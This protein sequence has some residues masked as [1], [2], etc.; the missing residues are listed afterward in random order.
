M[1]DSQQ[2]LELSIDEWFRLV[3]N[4][5]CDDTTIVARAPAYTRA[6]ACARRT[7]VLRARCQNYRKISDTH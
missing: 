4:S 3:L 5:V 7:R 1:T 2:K 6:C